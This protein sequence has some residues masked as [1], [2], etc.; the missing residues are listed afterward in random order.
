M[1]GCYDDED[2]VAEDEVTLALTYLNLNNPSRTITRPTN[3]L[4]NQQMARRCLLTKKYN[5]KHHFVY[6][7]KQKLAILQEAIEVKNIRSTARKYKVQPCQIRSWRKQVN[8]LKTKA[9]LNPNSKTIHFGRPVEFLDLESRLHKWVEEMRQEDIPVC[10]NNIIAQAISLDTTNTFKKG[11]AQRI[12]RWV[13]CFLERWNLSIRR[14]TRVGQKLSGHLQQVKQD[15]TTAINSRFIAG[16]TLENV[17]PHYFINMDQT[18]VY[19]ESKSKCIVAKKGARSVCARDSGSDAKRCTIVVTVAA[20][21]TKLPPFFVFKGQPGKKTE[22]SLLEQGI[23]GCCQP[24]AWFDETVYQKWI[25]AILEPYV[26]GNDDA[27]LLVDHYK[28]HM[29]RKF[30]TA[31][32][33]IGVDVDYIPAG[34]TCVLQPVDVGF[35]APFKRH[36]RDY[37]HKWCIDK[38]RGVSNA[39]KLPTPTR[40]DIVKWVTDAYEKIPE[41]SIRR[42]FISIGYNCAEFEESSS[43]MDT[44]TVVEDFEEEGTIN[45]H[46]L[47]LHV[48]S[49]F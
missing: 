18:A 41:E 28:V 29:M 24:N 17:G 9:L 40:D 23:K 7:I 30:V 43:D 26:R 39:M 49:Q 8:D 44:I 4:S 10:T 22:L 20:D 15:T 37:H 6:S 21:G 34:Y 32:N 11:N 42:T 33:D 1:E 38:Y 36:I 12:S 35:N 14:V 16:G 27:L 46:D 31:C 13:Y 47:Y 48:P 45:T 2:I 19:F 3:E 25:N 5:K